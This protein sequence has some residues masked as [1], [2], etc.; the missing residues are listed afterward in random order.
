VKRTVFATP[1]ATEFLDVR[2]FLAGAGVNPDDGSGNRAAVVHVICAAPQFVDK[3]KVALV[4]PHSVAQA[5]SDALHGA[6]K[7]LRREAEQRRKDAR[8]AER[9]ERRGRDEAARIERINRCSI[10]EAVFDVLPEAKS[11]AGD[12]VAARTLF[13]K[14]RPLVQQ[15]TDDELSYAYYSQTLLPDYERTVA[16]LPGLYYEARGELHHPHDDKGI[17]LGTREVEAYVPPSWQFGKVLYVEKAGL[18][19]QLKPYRLGPHYDMAVIYGKGYPPTA[20]RN[21]LARSEIREMKLF[22]LHDAHTDGYGIARTLAE[23][24][25][26]MP[27]HSIDVVDLGLSVHQAIEHGLETETFPRRKELPIDLEV[28]GDA[29][30]WFTGEPI[31]AGYGKVHYRCTRCE[32]NAFS[33][34]GL[35][36]F[37]EDGLQQHGAATKLVPPPDVLATHAQEAR[38]QELTELVMAELERMVDINGVVRHLI[39]THPHLAGV[40]E[41][42][43]RDRFTSHPAESWRVAAERLVADDI[44]AALVDDVR[45]QLQTNFIRR[46]GDV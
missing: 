27:D 8:N 16:P 23:A 15:F 35:A 28:D 41:A 9:D 38:D 18:E 46:T 43:V 3:G 26:R 37:I 29:R 25:R 12:V 19:A 34:D 20:C 6:T 39:A 4:V 42:R 5:A 45:A 21:L 2:E 1:R 40:D 36:E 13:Y 22:V 31:R 30:E 33:A 24:T 17:S 10:K 14:V 7:T 32:L 44:D 11:A